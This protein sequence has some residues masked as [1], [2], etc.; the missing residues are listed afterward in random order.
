VVSVTDPCDRIVDFLD[1]LKILN[2]VVSVH[3]LNIP[4]ERP[5]LARPI[6]FILFAICSSTFRKLCIN[7][8]SGM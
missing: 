6:N 1:R 7:M 5:P 8:Y 3:E 2:S 4:T